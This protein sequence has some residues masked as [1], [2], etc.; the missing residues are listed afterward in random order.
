MNQVFS[1]YQNAITQEA[2]QLR[3]IIGSAIAGKDDAS[4]ARRTTVRQTFTAMSQLVDTAM[5][6]T[7]GVV[8]TLSENRSTYLKV[9]MLCWY[10]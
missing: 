4:A 2:D 10:R 8:D 7:A 6:R 3:S 9:D 5:I 1:M